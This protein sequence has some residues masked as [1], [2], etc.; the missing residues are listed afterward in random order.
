MTA[1]RARE[2][3]ERMA[4]LWDEINP[5]DCPP[6]SQIIDYIHWV[7]KDLME[8]GATE[9]LQVLRETIEDFED[10]TETVSTAKELINM[11]QKGA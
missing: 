2:I 4:L 11:I 1:E 10:W 6:P 9:S 8:N 5:W 3:G 7:E